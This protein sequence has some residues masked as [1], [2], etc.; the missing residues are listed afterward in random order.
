MRNPEPLAFW[1]NLGARL[2]G[3]EAPE[4]PRTP[5]W[6]EAWADPPVL[7]PPGPA[8]VLASDPIRP[9]K[10]WAAT[11][12]ALAPFGFSRALRL[13]PWPGIELFLP[14]HRGPTAVLPQGFSGR[15]PAVERALSVAGRGAAAWKCGYR[16]VVVVGSADETVC[17]ILGR[18][19]LACATPDRLQ[20]LL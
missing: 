7:P 19:G 14:F 6:S 17:G 1:T 12:D 11:R 20:E 4:E 18:A 9:R 15:I 13:H 5:P 3:M 8:L 2:L 16:L 10:V